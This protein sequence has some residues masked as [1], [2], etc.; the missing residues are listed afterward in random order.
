MVHLEEHK[1]LT[2]NKPIED[3]SLPEAVYIP[4]SQH[5]GKVCQP[6]VKPKDR[7]LR[8]QKIGSL[9]SGVYAPVHASIS[10]EVVAIKNMPH[11]VLGSCL[12]VQIKS[13]GKDE[14]DKSLGTNSRSE[15]EIAALSPDQLRKLIFEA[16]IVGMGGA[17][18]PTHIKLKPPK[19][20]DTFILNGAECEPYLTSDFRLMVEHTREIMLGL[21]LMVRILGAKNVYIAIE[22][23]KPKAIEAFRYKIPASPA[24]RQDTCL[25]SRQASYK[26][27]I[28][29]SVYPQG[30]ERQLTKSVL[31]KEVPSGGLPFDIAVVVQNVSTAYAVYEAVYFN[32]PLYE[33]VVTVTGPL[34]KNPRNLRA[35]IGTPVSELIGAC[36]PGQDIAKVVIGGPMMGIAQYTLNVPVIKS[37][38]GI[39]LFSKDEVFAREDRVC[40]RCGRCIDV[41]PVRIMPAMIAMAAERER[42]DIARNYDPLDCIECGLCSY[43]CPAKRDLVHLI[44]YAKARNKI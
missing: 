22:D 24:G 10:G 14:P 4:L 7:V 37:T 25:A 31:N 27:Q 26:I 12:A 16:G 11:P 42:F 17:A 19:P 3:L 44:K 6:S 33:R 2:E 9:D 15:Q 5:L 41:C 35:R 21:N 39:V 34:L 20:V 1:D 43:V 38:G 8:G 29:K 13:D 36:E 30:G 18:F 40:C 23:N 32:K 28:L